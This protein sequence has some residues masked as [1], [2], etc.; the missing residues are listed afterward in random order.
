MLTEMSSTMKETKN[1]LANDPISELIDHLKEENRK[2]IERENRFMSL[3]T[4]LFSPQK[5]A[6]GNAIVHY[7]PH[8]GMTQPSYR[9]PYAYP[10]QN[11]PG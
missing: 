1:V 10:Q 3:M 7:P 2:E 11:H 5:T 9:S 6:T 8:N 4:N